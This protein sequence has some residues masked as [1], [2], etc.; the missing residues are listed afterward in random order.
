MKQTSTFC[1]TEASRRQVTHL[2]TEKY[3]LQNAIFSVFM[4]N[5]SQ[6]KSTLLTK[7][8]LVLL[9]KFQQEFISRK[10]L[11]AEIVFHLQFVAPQV[12]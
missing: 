12:T 10:I 7:A 1:I 4:L 6:D 8:L 9:Y 2:S 5:V 3:Q 11:I